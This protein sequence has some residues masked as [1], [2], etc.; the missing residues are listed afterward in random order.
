M[1]RPAGNECLP[2]GSAVFPRAGEWG[3]L[4]RSAKGDRS[5]R[6]GG[7]LVLREFGDPSGRP[8]AA[9]V[10]CPRWDLLLRP[11]VSARPPEEEH[12]K[13]RAGIAEGLN[14]PPLHTN[15]H[16]TWR[17]WE[18]ASKVRQCIPRQREPNSSRELVFEKS[19]S[20]R[21]SLSLELPMLMTGSNNREWSAR[22]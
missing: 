9:A 19:K 21:A 7:R 20:L 1:L 22:P 3:F 5:G 15:T 17:W 13:A 16:L 12:S 6:S 11:R 8:G 10:P 4:R 14:S 18:L 2:G